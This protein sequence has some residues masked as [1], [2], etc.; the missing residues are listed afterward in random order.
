[1]RYLISFFVTLF[2]LSAHAAPPAGEMPPVVVEAVTVESSNLSQNISAS[3]S[4]YSNESADIRPEISG[5]IAK[6]HFHDGQS[7]KKGDLLFTLD[8]S[9]QK[10]ELERARANMELAKNNVS[11]AKDLS[12]KGYTSEVRYEEAVAE[13]RLAIANVELA[14]ANMDKATIRAPFDG[15][16]GLRRVSPGDFVNTDTVMINLDQTTK[17]KI[18]FSIPERFLPKLKKNTEVTLTTDAYKGEN[19]TA[20]VAAF[21]SRVDQKNRSIM[22]QAVAE[23]PKNKLVAGQFVEVRL[24]ISEKESA[25]VIPD[26]ALVPIGANNYVFVVQDGAVKKIDVKTGARTQ[27]KV[28]ILEGLNQGDVIVTAGQQKLQDGAKVATKEPTTV[29]VNPMPEETNSKIN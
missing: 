29:K 4:V 2:A 5:R 26:Q 27:S 10:A 15:V 9:V 25:L 19:F 1:M 6:I 11:R 22:V 7:V 20:K 16:L 17:V 8:D 21:E 14:K 3:G 18:E 24:P 23:N 28:E 13:Q 12:K